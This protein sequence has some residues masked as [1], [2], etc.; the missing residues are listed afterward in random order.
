MAKYTVFYK[1][2][3]QEECDEPPPC[4][5]TGTFMRIE[6]QDGIDWW[7]TITWDRHVQVQRHQ[8]PDTYQAI[9]LLLN[10]TV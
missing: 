1:N 8:V 3:L 9:C 5:P 7:R 2:E 10:L 6:G 4:L